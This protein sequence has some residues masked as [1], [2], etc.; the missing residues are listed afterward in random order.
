MSAKMRMGHG[1][2]GGQMRTLGAPV[3]KAKNIKATVSRLLGY[4]KPYMH[5]IIIAFILTILS[6][7]LSTAAPKIMG[8]AIT[9]MFEGISAGKTGVIDY[10]Y[11]LKVIGV[12]FFIYIMNAGISYYTQRSLAVISQKIVYTLRKEMDEKLLRLPLKYF[13]SNP[14]GD[15]MSRISN[16]ADNINNAIQQGLPQIITSVIGMIGAAIM[17]L[18][19][20]P[21]LT[22]IAIIVLPVS[23]LATVL[24]TKASQK[25]FISQQKNLG[26]LNGHIEEMLSGHN[27]VKA[28]GYEK[29]SV[30]RFEKINDRLYDAGWKAQFI[31][32]FIF[33]L[34]GFI[35]NIGYAA[36]CIAGGIF[37]AMRKIALG[38]V[39]AFILYIRMF[40]Q[41]V[42]QAAG[43]INMLQSAAASAER[44]FEML[45][46]KEQESD[47]ETELASMVEGGVKFENVNF[48]YEKDKPLFVNLNIEAVNGHTVAIVGPTGAGK[49]TLVNLLMRFY[50]TWS[51]SI[52][53]DGCKSTDYKRGNLRRKFGMVLQDTWLFNGTIKENISYSRPGATD[54]E[55]KNAAAMAHAD[56]FIKAL[57]GGYDTV[58]NEEGTNI[59]QGEKQL[60]TIARAFLASPEMLILDEA[61]SSVDTRTEVLIQNAMEKLMNGRTS[62]V[63]AHRLSTIRNAELILVMEKGSIVEKGTHNELLATKGFYYELYQAQFAG[64]TV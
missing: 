60:L 61:T 63:I 43:I 49:T 40:T 18:V 19:I 7:V 21:A 20:S 1:P 57:P 32:A 31:S 44:V 64:K 5:I 23:M 22:A 54:D 56:H 4:L 15:I 59:S 9:K 39:Q 6:V 47:P 48:G 8:L 36:V 50:E 26:D 58:I 30:E 12:L 10:R 53:V 2:G 14:H 28:F 27:V 45:D 13:D 37:V 33:P 24:I 51:G 34:M 17:M 25:Y 29:R 55:I 16:D 41:P 46:G 35:G 52:I 62:F 38:D 3:E 42:A 11:L